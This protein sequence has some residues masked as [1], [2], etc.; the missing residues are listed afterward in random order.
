MIQPMNDSVTWCQVK[1]YN[2][3]LPDVTKNFLATIV[4]CL[5]TNNIFFT[6]SKCS[7]LNSYKN[8]LQFVSEFV[9][10]MIC[11]ARYTPNWFE[12]TDLPKVFQDFN[13]IF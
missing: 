7:I 1:G 11:S 12:E 13:K 4:S 6:D 10:S 2:F 5:A 8:A 3:F 9:F